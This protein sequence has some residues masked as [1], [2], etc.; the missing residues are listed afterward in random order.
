MLHIHFLYFLLGLVL[1]VKGSDFFVTASA[2]IAKR[3]GVS[4]FVIGLTLVAGG[5]SIPE[6]ASSIVA[7]IEKYSGII[8]GN[9]IGSNIANIGLIIGLSALLAEIKSN[10]DFL[11]RDGYMMIFVAILFYIL[12]LNG[13]LSKVESIFLLLLY[14]AYIMFLLKSKPIKQLTKKI[15]LKSLVPKIRKMYYSA[16]RHGLIKDFLIIAIS[17][18]AII[19]GAEYI[20]NEAVWL[21]NY[22]QIPSNLIALSIIAVGT[23]LPELGVSLSAV[24]KGFGDILLGNILGSNIVNILLVLGISAFI[25]PIQINKITLLYT[26]PFM[27]FISALLLFFIRSHWKIKRSEGAILL[28][29]YVVFMIL[30]FA[31][32]VF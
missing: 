18:F 29:A 2:R 25:N 9:I 17:I 8:I 15:S 20:V 14:I 19:Y 10:K 1:L 11:K 3:F 26:A 21:A 31:Y 28:S 7:S 6:L 5:T 24:K 30:I 27:I 4:E 16:F 22:F 12:A 13:I 23:S 32:G